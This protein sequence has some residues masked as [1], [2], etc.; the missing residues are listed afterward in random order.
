MNEEGAELEARIQ[1]LLDELV[2]SGAEI[3]LQVAVIKNGRAV[4][5]AVRGVADPRTGSYSGKSSVDR[6]DVRSRRSCERWSPARSGSKTRSISAYRSR[7]FRSLRDRRSADAGADRPNR[8]RDAVMNRAH[9]QPPVDVARRRGTVRRP[10]RGRRAITG[11]RFN[12]G[13]Q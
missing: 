10:T 6:R 7:F 3:G 5:D 1:V 4:V 8:R 13:L 11:R 9:Q 12:G 2:A